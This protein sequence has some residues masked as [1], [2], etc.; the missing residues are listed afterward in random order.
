MLYLTF[1][2]KKIDISNKLG[3]NI[4][5]ILYLRQRKKYLLSIMSEIYL[6]ANIFNRNIGIYNGLGLNYIFCFIFWVKKQIPAAINSAS[7]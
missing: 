4:Y 6:I 5:Y 1:Y 3:L 2:I 7:R